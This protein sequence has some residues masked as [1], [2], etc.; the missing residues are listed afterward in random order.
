MHKTKWTL[1][2]DAA[3]IEFFSSEENQHPTRYRPPMEDIAKSL[4]RTVNAIKARLALLDLKCDRFWLPEE[5]AILIKLYPIVSA[6]E[7]ARVINRTPNSIHRYARKLGF[8]N[9]DAWTPEQNDTL[10]RLYLTRSTEELAK[11]FG[12]SAETIRRHARHI[13]IARKVRNLPWTDRETD[14]LVSLYPFVSNEEIAQIL[15]ASNGGIQR[16]AGAVR[17]QAQR[18]GLRKIGYTWT[19]EEK[20]ALIK[21]YFKITPKELPGQGRAGTPHRCPGPPA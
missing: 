11:K 20:V 13:G 2:E 6:K 21:N 3:L 14:K 9:K 10:R 17:A 7:I 16:T 15:T 12:R 18:L 1:E 4:G 5:K 8:K 19:V